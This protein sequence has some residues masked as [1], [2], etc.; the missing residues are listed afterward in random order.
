VTQLV[1]HLRVGS[2]SPQL[3]RAIA[4]SRS[5]GVLTA[6]QGVIGPYCWDRLP[7]PAG[8]M[9]RLPSRASSRWVARRRR[10]PH[11]QSSVRGG[12]ERCAIS[13]KRYVKDGYGRPRNRVRRLRHMENPGHTFFAD[14]AGREI[15]R[16]VL[17]RVA[18]SPGGRN[19]GTAGLP[20]DGTRS[21]RRKTL[22]V[23]GCISFIVT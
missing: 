5:Q 8:R 13:S 14:S 17:D 20:G 18:V 15:L 21:R 3:S 23:T 22:T 6:R 10:Q 1:C 4:R 16:F 2:D 19:S 11:C 7:L 12:R 9:L